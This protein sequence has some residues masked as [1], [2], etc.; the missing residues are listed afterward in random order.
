MSDVLAT[1]DDGRFRVR[2]VLDEHPTNPR[3]DDETLVHVITIDTHLGQYHPVDKDGGPL[4]A[5]WERLKWD[6]WEGVD[7]FTRYVA[8][9]HGGIVLESAPERGPRSLWY[10]TGEE[11]LALDAGLLS[12][13]YIEAEMQEYEAWATGDVW[14]FIVEERVGWT[15]DDDPDQFMETW[16]PVDDCFG[17][18]GKP[19]ARSQ[20]R[21]ALAFYSA[22]AAGTVAA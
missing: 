19:Y 20:A 10:M 12:E 8:T 16:E 21:E 3:N 14:G 9:E 18:Y 7:R 6:R 15:R 5:E 17:F 11:I 1:T 13:G 22:R 2:L 4:A